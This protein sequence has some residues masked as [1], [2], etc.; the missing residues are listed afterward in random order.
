MAGIDTQI[1]SAHSTRSTLS[2]KAIASVSLDVFV[3]TAGSREE[4]T[5][6]RYYKRHMAI[7]DQMSNAVNNL[8]C[9]L[10][11]NHLD[12]YILYYLCVNIWGVA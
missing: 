10:V 8:M 2:N 1:F 9:T 12:P 7:I 6:R 4:S 3:K 11:I 5:F